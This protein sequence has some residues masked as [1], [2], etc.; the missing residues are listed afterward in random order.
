[1]HSFLHV[2]WLIYC[3]EFKEKNINNKKSK[4]EESFLGDDC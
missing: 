3:N 2:I 4:E 1:M